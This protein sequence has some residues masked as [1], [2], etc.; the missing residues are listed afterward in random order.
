MAEKTWEDTA[1]S[2][3]FQT[4]SD[5]NSSMCRASKKKNSLTAL[6]GGH[7]AVVFANTVYVHFIP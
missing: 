4:P 7:S 2:K 1:G 6:C 5:V 3:G